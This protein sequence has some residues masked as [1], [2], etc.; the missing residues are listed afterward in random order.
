PLSEWLA[1]GEER[2]RLHDEDGNLNPIWAVG[3]LEDIEVKPSRTRAWAD[4]DVVEAEE[5]L[6]IIL[7]LSREKAWKKRYWYLLVATGNE[8]VPGEYRAFLKRVAY[9][10]SQLGYTQEDI[11][12]LIGTSGN[13]I[14][15]WETGLRGYNWRTHKPTA[16]ILLYKAFL[17]RLEPKA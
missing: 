9:R 10:R 12:R 3:L 8:P 13:T 1:L 6:A 2:E 11:G 17:E 14:A 4:K 15:S 5:R 16:R 7:C